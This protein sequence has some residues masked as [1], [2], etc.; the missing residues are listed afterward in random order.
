[1]KKLLIFAALF[2]LGGSALADTVLYETNFDDM[3][4]GPI[5]ENY[6]D[7]W[8]K[9]YGSVNEDN[10]MN[11]VEGGYGGTG[12][13]LRYYS[14]EY[15]MATRTVIPDNEG[16]SL[17]KDFKVSFMVRFTKVNQISF[18]SNECAGE[19]L[20][21]K[22]GEDK[23]TI[24]GN[25]LSFSTTNS[26]PVGEWIPVS[27]TLNLN[28]G[29]R[30]LLSLKFGNVS[31][32]DLNVTINSDVAE[33]I[34]PNFLF[35]IWG[36]SDV[37]IDNLKIELIDRSVDN[38]QI[39]VTGNNRI[40]LGSD[41]A[42]IRVINEGKEP[43]EVT[44]ASDSSFMKL[45]G[46][47]SIVKTLVAGAST[48]VSVTVDRSQLGNDYY[49]AKV[50]CTC[51]SIKV[52][53]PIFIQSGLEG[54]GYTY[55]RSYFNEF[56]TGQ[57]IRTVDPA[58][59]AGYGSPENSPIVEMDGEKA[60]EINYKHYNAFHV[61]CDTKSGTCDS[62]NYRVSFKGYVPSGCEK[63]SQYNLGSTANVGGNEVI[64][65]ELP[66]V[67]SEERG[68]VTFT[69]M[70]NVC[71]LDEWFDVSYVFNYKP[72]NCR[73]ISITFGDVVSNLNYLLPN[74]SGNND[75]FN[76]FRFFGWCDGNSAPIYVKDLVI[77]SVARP[78]IG[79]ELEVSRG[80][81]VFLDESSSSLTVMNSGTGNL[82]FRAEVTTGGGWL[83]I[84]EADEETGILEDTI[85]GSGSKKY[86][87]DI[88]RDDL[89]NSYGFGQVTVTGAGETKV[90]N[91]FV[92]SSDE[93][94]VTLYSSDFE[95]ME[96]GNIKNV[97]P[98]WTGGAD[99]I[100]VAGSEGSYLEVT[101]SDQQLHATVKAPSGASADYNYVVRMKLKFPS[102]A[103]GPFFI[104]GTDL[105]HPQGEYGLVVDNGSVG[106]DTRNCAANPLSGVTVP[107][108]EWFDLAYTFN[109]DPLNKRLLSLTLGETTVECGEPIKIGGDYDFFN[110]FRFYVFSNG[111]RQPF[112]VDDLYIGLE[113]KDPTKPG[114]M[115]IRCAANP[116]AYTKS[117]TVINI[118]NAGGRAFTYNAEVR[119][120]A[121]WLTLSKYAGAVGSSDSIKATVDR[122][123][124]GYGFHRA[125]V[126]FTSSEGEVKKLTVGVQSGSAEE[127]YVLYA[128]DI[129]SLELSEITDEGVVDELSEQDSCWDRGTPHN[130]AAVSVDP[131]DSGRKCIQM[132]NANDWSKYCGYIL[133]VN[134]PA[135]A[136]E[137]YDIVVSMRM[138][139]P[140][141]YVDLP[142]EE[143]EHPY[144][145][146][147][148]SQDN[149]HRQNELYLYL[150]ENGGTMNVFA[151]LQDIHNTNWW[152]ENLESSVPV[153]N[154]EWF[155]YYT[156]FST[157]LIEYEYKR[158]FAF[159]FGEN[160]YHLEGDDQVI[161][162]PRGI[163]EGALL[164]EAMPTIKFFSYRDDAN[165]LMKDITVALIPHDAIP[166][167]AAL[168]FIL[169]IALALQRKTR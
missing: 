36:E 14:S 18:N 9:Y 103:T 142:V 93:T 77:D 59:R 151:D 105:Y 42:H 91:Y 37:S 102:G 138:L 99:G 35:F 92:Q 113:P 94:G 96:P 121:E 104:T 164:N 27:Y 13:S 80:G 130:C 133:N 165:I 81:Q 61:K 123:K 30:K 152:Y 40:S 10:Y 159:T 62:Y 79:P 75:Y 45:N 153:P 24:Q 107:L 1:M 169:L 46:E 160:E 97:D 39:A 90:V 122:A 108:G 58:W 137:E 157:K 63:Y 114:V 124:L 55:Y 112:Y 95:Y 89:G 76:W 101:G 100:V 44:I 85:I 29:N 120:G 117:E 11:V 34:F 15:M 149:E 156:R 83:S 110:E 57:D 150:D 21:L 111:E 65:Q 8:Y 33:D 166:E 118:L 119:Q 28:P 69:H 17:T 109:S 2:I 131:K 116:I 162:Y 26:C 7:S 144:S 163:S 106:V 71:P 127:G 48:T 126:K 50:K 38:V 16:R 125:V 87:M 141:T 161:D 134:A 139:V 70:G 78:D 6:P 22:D 5:F 147:F 64:N 140:D 167:P 56:E 82:P 135:E 168:G 146:F 54:D 23:F 115:D 88:V 145:A 52:D 98:A 86:T 67:Y 154:N 132:I 148:I 47:S 3:E 155:A 49:Y 84:R 32:E 20:F 12:R 41:T 25:D 129:D 60:L 31:Y 19:F 51:G 4:L 128:S 68:G 73:L 53:Y 143:Y 72:D 158:F 74:A 43:G 66:M 136:A